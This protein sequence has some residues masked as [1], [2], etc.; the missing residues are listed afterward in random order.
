MEAATD[1][2]LAPGLKLVHRAAKVAVACHNGSVLEWLH[3]GMAIGRRAQQWYN[4]Y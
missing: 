1:F 2:I 4:V 3:A